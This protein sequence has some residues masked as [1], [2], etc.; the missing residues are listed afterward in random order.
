[1]QDVF[2]RKT[3]D[4][5]LD[6]DDR[7]EVLCEQAQ[8]VHADRPTSLDME[9]LIERRSVLCSIRTMMESR[10]KAEERRDLE[11]LASSQAMKDKYPEDLVE[12]IVWR[13]YAQ[14]ALD[15]AVALRERHEAQAM[16]DLATHTPAASSQVVTGARDRYLLWFCN[17]AGRDVQDGPPGID[18]VQPETPE[19][20]EFEDDEDWARFF[21]RKGGYSS[22]AQVDTEG[23]SALMHAMQ[24]TVHWDKAWSCCQGL[25]GMMTDEGLRAK[26]TSG[27]MQG[28]SAFHMACNGSDRVFKRQNLVWLLID[29]HADLEC[30]NDKGLTPWLMAAGTGCV[31]VAVALSQ[32][33]CDT[34]AKTPEGTNAADRC[35]LSSSQ[36]FAYLHVGEM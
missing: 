30:R 25:I 24:A 12:G 1:M 8:K 36:M 34:T 31:D 11:L 10:R 23:W 33:G 9:W 7:W 15:R 26:A 20:D 5:Q 6:Y 29:R 21:C 32:A 18:C 35:Q 4:L 2:C 22:A 13:D 27:R 14:Q 3:Q 28:Y 19:C 16:L 17:A